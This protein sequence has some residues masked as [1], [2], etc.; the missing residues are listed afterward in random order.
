VNSDLIILTFSQE[1]EAF[2]VRQAL[3]IMRGRQLFGL[4][5]TALVTRDRAGQATI[6][7][8]W[9]LP[10][11]PRSPRRR[12]PVLFAGAI[13][14]DVP[15]EGIRKLVDAGLDEIFLKEVAIALDPDGSA[16][17]IYIPPDSIVD[18]RR[19]LDALALFHGKLHHTRIPAEVEK[20]I[21]ALAEIEYSDSAI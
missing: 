21:L 11:Y 10:A 4:E 13:F 9:G 8:R 5:N 16:L 20:A 7:Q 18:T 19:L 15:E 6:H 14:G 17:L 1:D 2:Q 12:L 3:E